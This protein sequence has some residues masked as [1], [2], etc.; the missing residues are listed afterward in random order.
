MAKPVA[1]GGLSEQPGAE[2][3]IWFWPSSS[4]CSRIAR[5]PEPGLTLGFP[6]WV[7]KPDYAGLCPDRAISFY[8][9]SL[10]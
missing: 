1:G 3:G 6:G 8:S 10:D 2:I 9:F 4:S 5:P 7:G